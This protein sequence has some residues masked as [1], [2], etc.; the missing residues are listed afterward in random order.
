MNSPQHGLQPTQQELME[1]VDGTLS[2]ARYREVEQFVLQSRR[3]QSEVKLQQ[4]MH[5]SIREDTTVQPSVSF[6][7]D[8]MNEILPQRRYMF[9]VKLANNSSN[10]FAMILVLSMIGIVLVSG[11]GKTQ[12]DSNI[13]SKTVESYSTAYDASVQNM[14]LWIQQITHPVNQAAASPSGKFFLIGLTAFCFVV[15]MD[16]IVGKRFFHARI[17]Q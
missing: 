17:K 2:L 4:T 5:R 1:F 11:P 13:L 8:V 14:E 6:T 16:E 3:L 15:I 9:W 7:T 10:F 12:N